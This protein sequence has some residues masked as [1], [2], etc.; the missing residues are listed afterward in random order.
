MK[1]KL[2]F[3]GLLL[4][5]MSIT[6]FAQS[7]YALKFNDTDGFATATMNTGNTNSTMTME[8]WFSPV[9]ST[10][11]TQYLADLHS[12]SGT[13]RRRV[14]PILE[15]ENILIIC[16][17]N[18]GNDNNAIYQN[19]GVTTSPG[20]W[21]HVAVT[22]NGS[23][24]KMYVNGTLRI[25]TSLTDSYALTG[26]EILSL[27]SDY[28]KT[29]L[30]NIKM[31]EVRIW[32]SERTETQIK[33]NMF[34][35]LAGNEGGLLSYYK[36]SNGS[37]TTLTDN[38]AAGSYPGTLSG[39]VI[40][41]AS[42]A[43]A[44]SRNALDFDGSND[45]VDCGNSASVQ[46]N[47][48]QPFTVEAW[49]KPVG[50]RWISV[51]SKFVHTASHEGYSLEIFSDNKVSLLY[52][53]NWSDWNAT[54]SSN[55]LTSGV[56][57]HIAATYD[58]STV[59]I[60]INGNLTQSAAWT[61]G[62][63]DSG[64]NLLIGSRSGSTFC[65]GQ[66]DEARVW[67][68]ARTAAQ[69]RESMA[70]T[71]AGNE[72]GLAAYYRLDELDGNTV[73]DLTSNANN[74]TLTNM[75]ALTDHVASGAFNT[76][77]GGNSSNWYDAGN[78]GKGAVPVSSD[79]IGIYKSGLGNEATISSSPTAGNLFISSSASP[80][81]SSALTVNGNLIL[82][83]NLNLNG[84]DITLGPNSYLVEGSGRAFGTSGTI[85]TTRTLSNISSLDVAGLGAR[86]ST[87]ANL[88]STTIT[89][90]HAQQ[91]SNGNVS[92]L[93][94]YDIVPT[95]NSAL[96]AS[97]VFN[98]NDAEL[99]SLT[100]SN[101]KLF[102]SS[103]NGA[104][105]TNE[106]GTLNTANNT[107]TKTE[108]SSFSRW[109]LALQ[110]FGI[111]SPTATSIAATSIVSTEAIL[112]GSVNANDA[113]TSVT[114]EYGTTT[115]YGTT[116]TADPSTVT[117]SSATSVSYSLSGLTAGTT[118]HYRVVG[119]NTGGTTN[120]DDLTFTTLKLSSVTTQAVSNISTNSATANGNI[121]DLGIPSPTAYG[122]CW[123][124]S[125][126]PTTANSKLDK[127]SISGTGAFSATLTGLGTYTTY[128][129]RA[130][131]IN[132]AGTSY[133]EQLSFTTKG[134]VA[135][136]TL[137]EINDIEP[138]T[139]IGKCSIT[140][141][142]F[143]NA[144]AYG[145]CWN[146]S[147]NP[148][149]FNSKIH[150]LGTPTTTGTFYAPITGL[151]PNTVYYARAYAANGEGVVYSGEV[152]FKTAKSDPA[153]SWANPS[154]IFYGTALGGLQLN[155]TSNVEGTFEYTP[156]AG[157][158]LNVG[159]A[160]ELS[161]TFTPKDLTK[162]EIVSKTVKIDVRKAVPVIT[163]ENPKDIENGTALSDL[164]LNAVAN[165]GGTF[166]Y[167]PIA[168][169]VLNTGS[170][171]ELTVR[172]SPADTEHYAATSDTVK[173]NVV[174]KTGID[175]ERQS[176]ISIYPNPTTDK[177]YISGIEGQTTIRISSLNG[178]LISEK[179]IASQEAIQVRNLPAGTYLIAIYN[180]ETMAYYK[181]VKK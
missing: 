17:P 92:I 132:G 69:L 49:V 144:T 9:V 40:W 178:K 168:G 22:I 4:L 116:V 78:W 36:M 130:Y 93:R 71:L 129:V 6:S 18:T 120:G 103:D 169:T 44:D 121:T 27:G 117:G 21:Y 172:F 54:T 58:G 96:N 7:N 30:A 127:G 28:W 109:T 48:T 156:A 23:T 126:N 152:S 10:G 86:I 142:G 32:S 163:W 146:T 167:D 59:K 122:F 165:I 79:N 179:K 16:A 67:T 166:V 170:L 74:G 115:S 114:F 100:E 157:T 136:V 171:Q 39:G 134:I 75:D 137:Y 43:F 161:V 31:D 175:S 82:E 143:P 34:K 57:S 118:Y 8:F 160:Q 173:I 176:P 133:G 90:G 85:A 63:T 11:G 26:T 38:Q 108:I 3:I 105:W 95:N 140:D 111:Q 148:T 80:T 51:I 162:N 158:K 14:M 50:G 128:Y 66:M 64:T 174:V 119:V 76:W 89:R 123:S 94:Y 77:I 147:P 88:G 73:Y 37:G 113:S 151:E 97:L 33:A 150:D 154:D 112:N 98:Y 68:V 46:R 19:T 62:V 149:M 52:G 53:N 139:A 155:A 131:S 1:T 124:A 65:L 153:I 72:A 104:T 45:Y 47:G 138:A 181:L 125:P 141:L 41:T 55:A 25:T 20:S 42:A 60:Y 84:Q 13:N 2:L 145:I 180:K 56:W 24:L 29:T 83:N 107:V 159:D 87:A 101:L 61:N 177:F 106:G 15:T 35:E 70:Q 12:I 91:T 164:Q 99:N 102:K 81:L 110:E 5:G 135:N